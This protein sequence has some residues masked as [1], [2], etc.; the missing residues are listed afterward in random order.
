MG[1]S[2]LGMTLCVYYRGTTSTNS[3]KDI[4]RKVIACHKHDPRWYHRL[5]LSFCSSP[6][7]LLPRPPL[8]DEHFADPVNVPNW[9]ASKTILQVT[10]AT[11]SAVFGTQM[12]VQ[13][14]NL[15]FL[16]AIDGF[17]SEELWTHWFTYATLV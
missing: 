12:S 1:L 16:V 4:K 8:A 6:S 14:K 5:Q 11:W 2:G 7:A 3:T 17:F 13:A 9:K 15:A 10:Y